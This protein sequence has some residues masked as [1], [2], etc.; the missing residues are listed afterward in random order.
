MAFRNNQYPIIL[1]FT[2]LNLFGLVL[3][4][5]KSNSLLFIREFYFLIIVLVFVAIG[6]LSVAREIVMGWLLFAV[7]FAVNML[8]E[9]YIF[10]FNYADTLLFIIL[11]VIGLFG[12]IFSLSNFV[13]RTD[14]LKQITRAKRRKHR[15]KLALKK[16]SVAP[17][18]RSSKEELVPSENPEI[19]YQN[20]SSAGAVSK[21]KKKS[22][23][24]KRKNK[25]NLK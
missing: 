19:V 23:K 24:K 18:S 1:A 5:P 4:L 9:F 21:K 14:K 15:R 6:L 16:L 2:V 7:F 11:I 25:K 20:P 12:F 13:R 10:S 17:V 3:F 8:N 22:T